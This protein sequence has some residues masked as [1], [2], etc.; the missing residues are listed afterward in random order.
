MNKTALLIIAVIS[1][2]FTT[3]TA[4]RQ[5]AESLDRGL[6]AVVRAENEVYLS[7]RL[8]KNDSADTAFN[9]YRSTGGRDAV[10]LNDKPI[11]KT[12]DFVDSGAPLNQ[13]NAWRVCPVIDGQEQTARAQVK[14]P[15]N[16]PVQPY[17]R[18]P[19]QGDYVCSKV[20]LA[21][22][23]GD[24]RLDYIIKQ[25][26]QVTD[27][28]VWHKSTDTFKVEAYLND[29]TFLWRKDLGPNIEQGVWWSP[30]V[31]FD[32]D[33][34][35][36]A[37]VAMKTAPTD[38][39]YRNPDGHQYPGRVMSGPEY[40]SI[41]DGITG[42]ELDRIDWPAR[43]NIADWGDEKN[44]RASRHLMGVAYLD[45]Q[46]PSLLVLRG[47][48]TLMRVD[49]YN[50]VNR[51]LETVWKWSGDD[52]S[53]KVRGQGMH[54][55]HA[56]DIDEDG[57]DEVI[58]GAAV[59]DDNGK[60]LW[61]TGMGH[62]DGC[63]VTDIYPDRPGLEIMYGIEPAQ[64][65]NAICV[66]DAKTGQILWGHDKPT[67]HIHSQG[68][69]A[70]FDPANPGLEYYTG[71]KD[72]SAYWTYGVNGRLLSTEKLESLSPKA[73]YWLDGSLKVY[74]DRGKIRFYK[75]KQIGEY[76]GR[77]LAVG[78]FIGDWREEF[79]TTVPGELRI[80]TTTIP[81][82]DRHAAFIQ[83]DIYRLDVAMVSMGYLY[84]PQLSYYFRQPSDTATVSAR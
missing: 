75:G 61:N 70:N 84:P 16:S 81:A 79:I 42:R 46:R 21:D 65:K 76:E 68:M 14:L 19:F 53:P 69:L 20:A 22:L 66:A 56:A 74:A 11:F 41:L 12:T 44:N 55:M 8:L 59:L 52:E 77:I 43:G 49:A 62:P 32:F 72:R 5:P 36:K 24:G 63:Y 38:V 23:N 80:Y 3:V 34:D 2:V 57:R 31:A 82:K 64:Q 50:L 18:M 58:L 60:I 39:D 47:T 83:D 9:I 67:T 1:A 10:K 33:G 51:K 48:Y 71:E 25:P 13:P 4:A 37:E 7:W 54:G 26:Q 6:V 15:A 45:G 29:G 17:I 40:C 35:G 30:M 28:G 73:L 27:P 78:D